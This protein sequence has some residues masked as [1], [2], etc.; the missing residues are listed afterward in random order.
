[1]LPDGDYPRNNSMAFKVATRTLEDIVNQPEFERYR[2][3]VNVQF[4]E[5]ETYLNILSSQ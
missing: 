5:A 3:R 2:H 4:R 1:M